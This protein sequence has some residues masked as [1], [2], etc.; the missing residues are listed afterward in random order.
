LRCAQ[1]FLRAPSLKAAKHLGTLRN[2]RLNLPEWTDWVIAPEE[3]K[4]GFPMC[5]IAKPG[6]ET[7]LKK[8]TLTNLY[9]QRSAWLNMA[10][11]ALD[12]AVANA[13]GWTDYTPEMADEEIL[14]RLLELNQERI[15]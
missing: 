1:R 15:G 3:Q 13:Y 8:R 4:A 14:R 12:K 2:N 6:V 5:P 10:H 9:N 11:K 7:K